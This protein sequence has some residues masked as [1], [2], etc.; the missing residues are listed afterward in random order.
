MAL[1]C[2]EIASLTF[3]RIMLKTFGV[4]VVRSSL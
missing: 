2:S 1:A 3:I 4:P